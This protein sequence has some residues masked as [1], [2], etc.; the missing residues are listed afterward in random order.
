MR[1]FVA[2][3]PPQ[4]AIAD[5]D[6]FL[7]PRRAAGSFRWTLPDQIHLTLAFAP[8]VPDHRLDD[9]VDRLGLAARRRKTFGTAIAGAGAFPDPA[10]GRVLYASLDLDAAAAT[11]L[12]RLATGCRAAAAT[13]GLEVNGQRFRPHLTVARSGRPTE[14]S[15]WVR[16]LEAYRGPPWVVDEVALVASHLGEGPRRSPRYEVVDTFRLAVG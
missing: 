11:E 3:R 13:A 5:L 15:N 10:R 16:L 2:V 1:M 8:V 12:D 6:D 14:L 4:E 7:S 9:L